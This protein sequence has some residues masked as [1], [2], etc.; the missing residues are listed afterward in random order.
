VSDS[1]NIWVLPEINASDGEISKLSLGL[2]TEAANIAVKVGGAVTAI[3]L[4]DE[5]HDYSKVLGDYGVSR[6]YFFQ[7]PLLE[8]FSAEAYAAALL[9]KIQ[10]EKPWLFLM[11]DTTV[12]RELATRLVALLNTGLVTGCARIDLFDPE[13]PVFYRPVYAGQLYQEV[14]LETSSTMVVTIDP[15]VLN[16]KEYS[17]ATNVKTEIIESKLPPESIK[18]RHVEFL[19]AEFQTVDVAD[20]STII[21][22]GM[23]AAA[24]DLLP[25]VDE[26]AALLE[27]AIGTTRPVIDTGKIPRERMIGQTGRVVGPDFYLALGI[28][29]ASHHVGG[30]QDSGKIV[31]VN[32]DPQ[33]PIFQSADAGAVADLRDVLPKL[34]DRIKRAKENGEIL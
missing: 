20:A 8:Y 32:R 15:A 17:V 28:S 16:I 21:A 25:L 13:R 26:L 6:A 23:G 11:G 33:A 9:I 24:D 19:P 31:A 14:V 34:I 10:E 1:K 2:L 3:A 12:G 18:F 4:G 5:Y 7:D 27:G 29:G 30:I 22:A